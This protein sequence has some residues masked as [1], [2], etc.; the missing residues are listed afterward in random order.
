MAERYREH[1]RAVLLVIEVDVEPLHR[2]S[3][4]HSRTDQRG[5][6]HLTDVPLLDQVTYVSHRRRRAGLQPGHGEDAFFLRQ[7]GQGLRLFQAV[8]E[9]PFAIDG[10]ARVERYRRKFEVIRH[11]HGDGDDVHVS[12]VHEVL[13]IV[14]R[15]RY[16][17]ELAG[18]VG[19]LASGGGQRRDLE[20]IRERLQSRDVP[21][22]RPSAIWIGADDANTNP[23]VSI[24][25]HVGHPLSL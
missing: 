16:T 24:L 20:V 25:T 21:L 19:R 14:E 12:P 1:R 11:F 7:R 22:S 8:A 17:K 3:P 10:L 2:W 6:E 4:A 23:L 15:D 18:G 5:G 9:R 13:V